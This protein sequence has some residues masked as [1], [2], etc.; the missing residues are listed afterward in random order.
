MIL[1]FIPLAIGEETY[2]EYEMQKGE[3]ISDIL[4]TKGFKPLYGKHGILTE[5]LKLNNLDLEQA[6]HIKPGQKV[7][8]SRLVQEVLS[9]KKNL[10][11]VLAERETKIIEPQP[12]IIKK[13]GWGMDLYF[14]NHILEED[15]DGDFVKTKKEQQLGIGI[16]NWSQIGEVGFDGQFFITKIQSAPT[17]PI[18]WGLYERIRKNDWHWK[19]ITPFISFGIESFSHLTPNEAADDFEVSKDLLVLS[20]TGIRKEITIFNKNL[21]MALEFLFVP[22]AKSSGPDDESGTGLM[23]HPWI[24][25]GLTQRFSTEVHYQKLSFDS[26]GDVT[27]DRM[28]L[29][30]IYAF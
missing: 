1:C 3:T 14:F 11:E 6:R 19:G 27:A 23:I 2:V 18:E 28:N 29:N 17:F 12:E 7:K 13:S 25:L 30:L 24:N 4:W 21:M 10:K 8:V 16:R 22:I 5:I 9:S 26:F 20:G 15:N